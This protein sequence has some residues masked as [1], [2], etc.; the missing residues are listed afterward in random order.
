MAAV[1]FARLRDGRSIV[2]T[3]LRLRT[4]SQLSEGD[5]V[6]VKAVISSRHA[7]AGP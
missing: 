2:V 4:Y 5:A 3:E 6:R 1:S 7:G